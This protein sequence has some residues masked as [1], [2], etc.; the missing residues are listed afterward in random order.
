MIEDGP[1][2]R[3][4]KEFAVRIVNLHKY[5]RA[6]KRESIMANQVLRCGTS[7]AAN[8]AEAKFGASRADFVNRL[9]IALKEANETL[10]WIELLHETE[11]IEDAPF[12]SISK[13]CKSIIYMLI[14]IINST[15]G[16]K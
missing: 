2:S 10:Y 15:E 16:K 4:S 7:I 9:R 11:Y 3:Q 5:L 14:S 1:L 8:V 13:D 12:E 6:E